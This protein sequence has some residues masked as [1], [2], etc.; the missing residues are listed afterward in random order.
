MNSKFKVGDIVTFS[1]NSEIYDQVI[2]S[3]RDNPLEIVEPLTYTYHYGKT[4]DAG[5]MQVWDEK[6]KRHWVLPKDLQRGLC[7]IRKG[8]LN[9]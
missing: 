6:S 2:V 8:N 5:T 3:V 4:R 7:L 9:E 1:P